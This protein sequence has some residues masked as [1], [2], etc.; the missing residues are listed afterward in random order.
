MQCEFVILSENCSAI[1]PRI[2]CDSNFD[3]F[4][5]FVTPVEDGNHV[6]YNAYSSLL[7][8]FIHDDEAAPKDVAVHRSSSSNGHR[9]FLSVTYAFNHQIRNDDIGSIH[10]H[11]MCNHTSTLSFLLLFICDFRSNT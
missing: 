6:S 1:I 11:F 5:A 8:N 4:D 3:C 9:T 2:K 7:L 10:F